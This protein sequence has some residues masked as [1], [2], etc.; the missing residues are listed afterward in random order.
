M[1]RLAQEGYDVQF[2]APEAD[3]HLNVD[4]M[5]EL[6]DKNTILVAAMQVNKPAPPWMWP[7]WPLG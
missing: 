2:V 5:L 1:Q 7:A 4:K 6:V 3:G